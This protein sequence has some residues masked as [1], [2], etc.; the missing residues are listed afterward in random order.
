[1]W[2]RQQKPDA[3]EKKGKQTAIYRH[4]LKNPDIQGMTNQW[5]PRQT[6][7]VED[8][9][10]DVAESARPYDVSRFPSAC[11][12]HACTAGINFIRITVIHTRIEFLEER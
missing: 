9:V 12:K 5:I 4:L 2:K 6:C 8:Q 3:H 7:R 10:H 11:V 1:M